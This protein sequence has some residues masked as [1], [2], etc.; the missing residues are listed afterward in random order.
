MGGNQDDNIVIGVNELD[1]IAGLLSGLLGAMGFGGGSILIIYLTN[2]ASVEQVA[3]QGINLL[4]FIPCAL[5]SVIYNIRKRLIKYKSALPII[6]GA[7]PGL[8]LGTFLVGGIETSLLRKLFGAF[9]VVSGL[10]ILFR[11]KRQK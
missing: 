10:L 4:F 2:M 6:A 8:V 7:I 9:L 1:I 5:V 3:A 11:S